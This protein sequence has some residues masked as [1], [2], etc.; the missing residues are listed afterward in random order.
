[1]C[2]RDSHKSILSELVRRYTR[3]QV[4]ELRMLRKNAAPFWAQVESVLAGEDPMA[5]VTR[6]VISDVTVLKQAEE[7][8][9]LAQKLEAEANLIQIQRMRCV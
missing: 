2:I 3:M 6:V 7:T 5:P 4:F 9:R 1:M 8:L